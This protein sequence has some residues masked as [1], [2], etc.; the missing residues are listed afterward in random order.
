MDGNRRNKAVLSDFSDVVSTRPETLT[1]A[2]RWGQTPREVIT[3]KPASM[4][5]NTIKRPLYSSV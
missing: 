1:K 5:N 3:K 2:I 4:V